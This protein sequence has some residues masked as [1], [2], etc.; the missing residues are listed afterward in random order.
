[1]LTSMQ[2]TNFKSYR[3]ARLDLA[4]LT[5][6]IGPNASGK[7]NALEGIRLLN[8]LAK[9]KRLDDIERDIQG[10]DTVV[11]GQARDLFR[12]D[13]EAFTLKAHL[14]DAPK[15]WCDFSIT[16]DKLNDQLVVAGEQ[17]AHPDQRVPLYQ[18]DSEPNET[19]VGCQKPHINGGGFNNKHIYWVANS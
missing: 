18:V 13:G 2:L 5:F 17:I 16:I 11:R 9:G 12:E 3:H 14:A 4:A 8:W 6:L 15:G 7:S 19:V 1:M 10:G